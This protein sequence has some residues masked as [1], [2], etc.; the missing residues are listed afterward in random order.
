[1]KQISILGCGWLGLPLAKAL[2]QNGFSI[3]GST[4]SQEKLTVLKKSKIQPF[5]IALESDNVV[6]AVKDFLQESKTL[7]I[8]ITPKLRGPNK[9]DFIGKIEMLIPYIEK[10]SIENVLFIS[11]TS[12]YGD[13]NDNV[14]EESA[15]NPDSEGGKQLAIVEKLL[16]T[17][18]RF[19]TTVLRFG[20]LI[21]QDRHPVRFLAGRDNLDNPDAP[22]NLIHQE[23]CIGIILKIIQKNAWEETFNAS[24][25]FHPSRSAYYSQKAVELNLVPPT[26]NHGNPSVGKTILSDKLKRVLD[27][28]FTKTHL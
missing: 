27:Y 11:S 22:I 17:N 3:Y 25:P 15:L 21:G 12:V 19:K 28:T 23:D 1:M 8:D 4:T 16:Q 18:T 6:G 13:R 20:G 10:S 9:E 2:V 14:T 26:F 7:I 24:T 5:L